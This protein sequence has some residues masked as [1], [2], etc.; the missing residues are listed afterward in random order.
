[1][2]VLSYLLV[3]SVAGALLFGLAVTFCN[4]HVARATEAV[5]DAIEL[6]LATREHRRIEYSSD[7]TA[8]ERIVA[9]VRAA[10]TPAWA[11]SSSDRFAA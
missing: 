11:S 2:N 6:A 10:S 5:F 7:M 3:G 9:I 8:D 1:M 4:I